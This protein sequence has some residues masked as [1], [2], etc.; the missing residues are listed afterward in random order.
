[1]AP[2]AVNAY[3]NPVFNEIVFL[4]LEEHAVEFTC[5]VPFERFP[6]LKKKV[7]ERW[8]MKYELPLTPNPLLRSASQS[9]GGRGF[10]TLLI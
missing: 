7:E 9:P 2:H 6:V 3:Y 4:T 8:E 5:S 10:Q 1:M